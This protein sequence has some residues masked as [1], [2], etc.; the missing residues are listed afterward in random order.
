MKNVTVKRLALTVTFPVALSACA[1]EEAR[2]PGSFFGDGCVLDLEAPLCEDCIEFAHVTRLGSDEMGPG[3]LTDDGTMENVVRDSVGNYW[4][5][6]GE[7]IKVFDRE[8]AFL[9]A[10]GR[11]GDG[12]MEFRRAAP[13]HADASGRVHVFDTGNLRIS[14]IDGA[15]T[16]VEEKTLPTWISAKTPLDDGDRYVVHA[17]IEEPGRVGMPLHTIDET[18]ILKSFGAGD[19]PDSESPG[20]S[21]PL[22]LTLATDG[23]GN[24]LTARRF[25]YVIDVWSQEGSRLGGLRGEPLLNRADFRVEAPSPDNPPPSVVGQVRTDSDGLL[26]VSLLIRRP[27]WLETLILDPSGDGFVEPAPEDI[28]GVYQGRLD[29]IDLA[30]CTLVASQLHDQFLLLL[31]DRTVLG[32]G[33]T[34]LGA[35]TLDVLRVY[36]PR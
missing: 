22:E 26:W 29:V 28:T 16:L 7:Q 13:M 36:L 3:F 20:S 15:F 11:R 32:Y 4:V 24:V 1:E 12:P 25:E 34:E 19:E 18:G 9:R 6:Q 8:G 14:L 33:F 2:E 23:D 17:S 5:G 10:V 31:D 27:D 30:M 35:N 21:M